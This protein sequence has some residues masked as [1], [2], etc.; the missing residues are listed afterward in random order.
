MTWIGKEGLIEFT[1]ERP[2]SIPVGHPAQSGE[3]ARTDSQVIA[4][5]VEFKNGKFGMVV[6][7]CT[8]DFREM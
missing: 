8:D 6:K 3:R 7:L 4:P 1:L 5:N 2:Q